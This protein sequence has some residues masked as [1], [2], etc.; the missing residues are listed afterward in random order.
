MGTMSPPVPPSGSRA[1][2]RHSSMRN[3]WA[4][5]LAESTLGPGVVGTLPAPAADAPVADH[6]A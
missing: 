3:L 1:P 2:S 4:S 6:L 5:A